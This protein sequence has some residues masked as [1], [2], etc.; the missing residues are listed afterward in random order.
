MP[1]AMPFGSLCCSGGN[2]FWGAFLGGFLGSSLFSGNAYVPQPQYYSN[3]FSYGFGAYSS[4]LFSYA[5]SYMPASTMVMPAAMPQFN[6][7]PSPMNFGISANSNY[8]YSPFAAM[9]AEAAAVTTSTSGIEAY[10]PFSY[11]PETT[12]KSDGTRFDSND[13]MDGKYVTSSLKSKRTTTF[14]TKTNLPQLKAVGYSAEK[15]GRLAQEA[16]SHVTGFSSN[17]GTY[18]RKALERA[19]L[20]NGKRTG[21]AAD[22]GDVLLKQKNFKE[23]STKGLDLSSLPAGCVLV[24][25]RGVSG[26]DKEH[27]HVEITLG[28]GRAASDKNTKNIR[29]GARV[30]VPVN[31]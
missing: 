16:L 7:A 20:D 24:Y 4:P 9:P 18:V 13:Y 23:I 14:N 28:D 5:P 2:S 11:K 30:F 10:N 22:F 26:Y 21:S 31:A 12:K 8:A 17:C 25:G 3:N 6:L 29:K 1:M 15:G 19:H 27:G